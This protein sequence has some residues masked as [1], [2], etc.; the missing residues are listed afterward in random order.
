MDITGPCKR[1]Q[2]Y[3]D[4]S[5]SLHG[6]SLYMTILEKLRSEGAA[7]AMVTRGL[8]GFGVHSRIHRA[9]LADLASPL[10][11]V[12]TW[13]DRPELVERLLPDISGL[14]H[15]GLVTVEDTTVVRYNRGG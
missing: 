6:H 13:V 12:I 5:D 7:G 8:A 2:I 1:V 15:E 10:P 14:V 11:L 4:E 9:G 3:V